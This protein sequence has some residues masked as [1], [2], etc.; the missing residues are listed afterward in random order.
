MDEIH[1]SD[2]EDL[3][4]AEFDSLELEV[5]RLTSAWEIANLRG[6][7]A[8]WHDDQHIGE[9]R[10]ELWAD[11]HPAL[12]MADQLAHRAKPVVDNLEGN[13]LWHPITTPVIE[14]S[15]DNTKARGV[16]WSV[17][18]ESLAKFREE[19]MAILSVGMVPGTH[20]RQ[21]GEWR[22]LAGTWQRTVKSDYLV[23]WIDGHEFTNTRP[24][25]TLE[26]DRAFLGRYAYWKDGVRQ[27]V[28]EPPR[29]DT[30]EQFPDETDDGWQRVNL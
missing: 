7:N 5:A 10:R 27:P 11:K 14:V 29:A 17:G 30:W 18:F 15:P 3:D 20:V 25:L 12:N 2:F 24:P 16:W 1:A 9:K 4:D 23:G 28:P 22:I 19:P 6:Q 13:A 26:Q 8:I 21:D